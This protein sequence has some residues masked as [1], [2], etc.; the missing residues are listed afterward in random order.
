MTE[1][2]F[3]L[4]IQEGEFLANLLEAVLKDRRV[5]EHRTRTPTYR[6]NILHDEDIIR[7]LLGKLG[8]PTD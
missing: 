8:H 6:Q 3:S 2:Q 7:S 5:E 1:I 4:T